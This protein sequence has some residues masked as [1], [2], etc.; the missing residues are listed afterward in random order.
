[1][2]DTSPV[3]DG[4]PLIPAL[5]LLGRWS[6]QASPGSHKPVT[7]RSLGDGSLT[8][9]YNTQSPTVLWLW[10]HNLKKKATG[11]SQYMFLSFHDA[12]RGRGPTDLPGAGRRLPAPAPRPEPRLRGGDLWGGGQGPACWLCEAGETNPETKTSPPLP[13]RS[14]TPL[15]SRSRSAPPS[16]ASAL[17]LSGPPPHPAARRLPAA[18][19][20]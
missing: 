6:Y 18:Q 3:T 5:L 20:L 1:M 14:S 4:P 17:S 12:V 7:P 13:E 2:A 16:R 9:L 8:S 10:K 15:G 19:A 11:L